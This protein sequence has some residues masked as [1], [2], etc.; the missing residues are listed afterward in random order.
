M[1]DSSTNDGSGRN[2]RQPCT[3]SSRF[4]SWMAASMAAWGANSSNSYGLMAMPSDSARLR[5]VRS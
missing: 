2:N 1:C 4:T 5:A 3:F